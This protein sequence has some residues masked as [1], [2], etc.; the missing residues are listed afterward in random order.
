VR[1]HDIYPAALAD[2]PENGSYDEI[3]PVKLVT[4]ASNVNVLSLPSYSVLCVI[5]SSNENDCRCHFSGTTGM[6]AYQGKQCPK[7]YVCERQAVMVKSMTSCR[8][9]V[10]PDE[11]YT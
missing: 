10:R 1:G 6:L 8:V 9:P 2:I 5:K 11:C 7:R 3:K 4:R